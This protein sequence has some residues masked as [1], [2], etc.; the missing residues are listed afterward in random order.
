[1]RFSSVFW[2]GMLMLLGLCPATTFG[3]APGR[4]DTLQI[5]DLSALLAE[6]EAN[7]PSL[8]AARLDAEAL[9]T[10]RR[11]VSALPDPALMLSYQPFPMLTGHG[12]QRTMWGVEQMIPFPGKLRLQGDIAD[13]RADVAAF[14]AETFSQDLQLQVKQVYYQLYHV[15]EQDRLIVGFQDE[16]HDFEEVA[17]TRYAVGVGTQQDIL[18]AQVEQNRLGVRREVLAEQRRSSLEQL[19]RLLNRPGVTTLDGVVR[20]AQPF[21][22]V[23]PDTLMAVALSRRPEVRALQRADDQAVRQIDLAR[24]AFWPDLMLNLTYF[25]MRP[26]AAP[27]T[28]DGTD[29][30][31]IGVGVKVPLWRGKLRAGLEEARVEKRQVEVRYEAL[32]AA[33]R[34]QLDD[35]A[36]QLERQQRQLDLF[37]NVLLPQ[38]EI[39]REATLSA[40]NTGRTSFLDLLDAERT[41]FTLRLDDLETYTRYLF[42]VAA[43]ERALGVTS[44]NDL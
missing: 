36:Q 12:F 20:V 23:A 4:P 26:A 39:T 14:E 33:F 6:L 17:A 9:G 3:Q 32:E 13:L 40:Y 41:L 11:Q 7:N 21:L 25:D 8:Q 37:R 42:T 30:F 28:A 34:A 18:K 43:L 29:A 22:G 31:G 15:Q 38:A 35:L 16:L 10:R 27:P 24:R 44:L 5:L 2:G 1:M 19:A